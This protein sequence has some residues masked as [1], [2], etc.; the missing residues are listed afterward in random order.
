M[1]QRNTHNSSF[2]A[3]DHQPSKKPVN[4]QVGDV[5]VQARIHQDVFVNEYI[6]VKVKSVTE[7]DD[8]ANVRFD[9]S[10]IVTSSGKQ[11]KHDFGANVQA[12]T[13][14]HQFAVE[15]E[16]TGRPVYIAIETRRRFR[17]RQ[18]QVIPYT[19]PISVLRGCENGPQSP[20]NANITGDNCSKALV[21]MGWADEPDKTILSAESRSNP[22]HWPLVR[23]N[24]DGDL[25]PEGYVIPTLPDGQPVGGIIKH[26]ATGGNTQALEHQIAQLTKMVA[27]LQ[28]GGATNAAGGAKPWNDRLTTG[29]VNPASYAVTQVRHT[30]ETAAR[31]INRAV[32]Q[33]EATVPADTLRQVESSLTR[34]LLWMA[35]RTQHAVTGSVDRMAKAHTEAGAWVKYVI[36]VE[37]PYTFNMF[38]DSQESK[39]AANAW[40]KSVVNA[41]T[42]RYYEAVAITAEHTQ[43]VTGVP[44]QEQP[45]RTAS[46]EP[47]AQAEPMFADDAEARALWDALIEQIG[48]AENVD[49]L[50]PALRARFGTHLS[51]QIT[52]AAMREALS[53][54]MGNPQQFREWAEQAWFS[55]KETAA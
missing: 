34:V 21:V 40:A 30:R 10:S 11:M 39:E 47:Q 6:S 38:G 35:D 44:A 13:P 26:E 48:M 19:T 28:R 12:G 14:I 22:T 24:Q 33:A 23:G 37:N 46:N 42:E 45:A 53:E 16:K 4:L 49:D 17:D 54:W 51:T 1:F 25:P 3:Y 41:A 27:A 31:I 29:E 52:A 8:T 50:N 9:A 55:E 5:A 2:I 20:A 15:A 36:D 18:G 43:Q 32:T 7:N